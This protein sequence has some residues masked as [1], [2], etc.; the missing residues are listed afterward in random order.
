M[1]LPISIDKLSLSEKIELMEKLW[2]DL[3]D[4]PFFHQKLGIQDGPACG[5]ANCIV[6]HCDVGD[7]QHV[8]IADAPNG[9]L[10]APFTVGMKA[11]LRVAFI[12]MN[13]NGLWGC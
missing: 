5:T 9:R 11:R 4:K 10:H 12:I 8:G 7:I 2:E 1:S 13:K 3:S 6:R